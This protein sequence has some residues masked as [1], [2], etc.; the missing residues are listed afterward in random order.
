MTMEEATA[1]AEWI[2]DHDTRYEAKAMTGEPE[3][4]VLLTE[5]ADGTQ[6]EPIYQTEEYGARY[7]TQN[8]PGPTIRE[9]WDKWRAE[10]AAG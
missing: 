2:K 3:C 5:P 6:L 10:T 7:V 1:L 8:D 9:A 4:C